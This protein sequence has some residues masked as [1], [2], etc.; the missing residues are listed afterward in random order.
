MFVDVLYNYM[1][2]YLLI[3]LILFCHLELRTVDLRLFHIV[4]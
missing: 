3:Q 1:N 2:F 4:L